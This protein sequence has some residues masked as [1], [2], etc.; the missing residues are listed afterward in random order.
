MQ[1]QLRSARGRR[2]APR[3]VLVWLILAA[4]VA[5]AAAYS[6]GS[7]YALVAGQD[8]GRTTAQT[9]TKNPDISALQSVV[10]PGAGPQHPVVQPLQSASVRMDHGHRRAFHCEERGQQRQDCCFQYH[11]ARGEPS[12]VRAPALDPPATVA[13]PLPSPDPSVPPPSQ[14]DRGL[15]LSLTQLSIS[16][17]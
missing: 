4:L 13:G 15:A 8:S 10:V 14:K 7:R 17:T 6:Q 12:P 1:P 5:G 16:R 2:M 11:A 9:V 3:S